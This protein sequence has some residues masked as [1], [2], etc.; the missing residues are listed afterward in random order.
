MKT[1]DQQ[2][3]NITDDAILLEECSNLMHSCGYDPLLYKEFFRLLKKITTKSESFNSKTLNNKPLELKKIIDVLRNIAIKALFFKDIMDRTIHLLNEEYNGLLQ[4]RVVLANTIRDSSTVQTTLPLPSPRPIVSNSSRIISTGQAQSLLHLYFPP[5][6]NECSFFLWKLFYGGKIVD[7]IQVEASDLDTNEESDSESDLESWCSSEEE[8]ESSL[9][10]WLQ[11]CNCLLENVNSHVI[12]C[13]MDLPTFIMYLKQHSG[14][15]LVEAIFGGTL[16]FHYDGEHLPFKHHICVNPVSINI[17]IIKT[18][19]DIDYLLIKSDFIPISE[20]HLVD[21]GKIPNFYL[22]WFGNLSRFSL[23]VMF[24]NLYCR[25]KHSYQLIG[26]DQEFFINNILNAAADKVLPTEEFAEIPFKMSLEG[27]RIRNKN[28]QLSSMGIYFK[29]EHLQPLVLMM[30]KIINEKQGDLNYTKFKGFFFISKTY[31]TKATFENL[32]SGLTDR[33]NDINWEVVQYEDVIADVGY[34][35]IP[36][37]LCN[38]GPYRSMEKLFWGEEHNVLKSKIRLDQFSN[39]QTLGDCKY[40]ASRRYPPS[41]TG[42]LSMQAYQ[43]EQKHSK[44]ELDYRYWKQM[45]KIY[46]MSYNVALLNYYI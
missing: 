12:D 33:F 41:I 29:K 14:L 23:Y 3:E 13:D 38:N 17:P 27:F 39:F 6:Q 44:I 34:E 45:M 16:Q 22:G 43:K 8:N 9:A 31:G 18:K 2:K 37:R 30:H 24:P 42:L 40:E 46:T 11:V 28:E 15:P 36:H 20:D 4:T 32:E 26:S 5:I 1:F 25:K 7:R 19:H 35:F 21:C 10:Q